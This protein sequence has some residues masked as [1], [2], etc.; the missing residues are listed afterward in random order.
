MTWW[1]TRREARARLW[2]SM[3]R[4]CSC[5]RLFFST[6]FCFPNFENHVFTFIIIFFKC[7]E[8]TTPRRSRRRSQRR[9]HRRTRTTDQGRRHF[10][11]FSSRPRTFRPASATRSM[12]FRTEQS[13]QTFDPTDTA[14]GETESSR[15]VSL[16][17]VSVFSSRKKA[18]VTFHS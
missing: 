18:E 6:Q 15:T 16:L 17:F 14:E 3:S 10:S 13:H 7:R 1:T 9:A 2:I 4:V 8:H 11:C 12:C 5:R